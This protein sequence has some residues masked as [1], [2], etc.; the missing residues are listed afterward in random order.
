ME[1]VD[2]SKRIIIQASGLIADD[3]RRN[4]ILK[5]TLFICTDV[6]ELAS[7]NFYIKMFPT[8]QTVTLSFGVRRTRE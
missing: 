8:R 6:Y 3:N 2:T 1:T 7:Y 5:R 4:I